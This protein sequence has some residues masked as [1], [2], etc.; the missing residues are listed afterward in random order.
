MNVE[1]KYPVLIGHSLAGRTRLRSIQEVANFICTHGQ[2][3]DLTITQKDGT[4]FLDTF[5]IYINKIA[6]MEYREEL[7]KVLIPMQH[8]VER[9]CFG[10]D[11]SDNGMKMGEM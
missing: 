6:D 7:L 4:P 11:E 2:Y 1:E 5:G 10:Y 3:D 9:S 8:E